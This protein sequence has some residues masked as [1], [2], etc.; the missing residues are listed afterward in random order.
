VEVLQETRA[1]ELWVNA[2]AYAQPAIIC[3][4]RADHP[5]VQEETMSPILVVQRAESFA[6]AMALCNGTRYGL[7]AALFSNAREIQ[8]RFLREAQAG[9]LKI[10]T[11]TAGADVSLPFGGWKASGLGP[12]EHGEADRLFYTRM[13]SVYG[14]GG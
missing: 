5:L 3:C 2:G 7:A 11:S 6:H 1:Q 13:Q 8:E 14:A 12:P 4:D 9:I 10:N